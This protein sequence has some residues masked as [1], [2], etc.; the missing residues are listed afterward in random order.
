MIRINLLGEEADNSV[1]IF[2]HT[3]GLSGSIASVILACFIFHN[4]M[5]GRLEETEQE[6]SFSETTLNKLREKTKRVEQL[7]QNKNLL[8]E[9]LTTIARLKL[10]KNGPVHILD[11]LISAIP[12]RSWMTGI[13]NKG[14]GLQFEG[15]ALDPQTVSIFMAKLEVSKWFSTVELVYSSQVMDKERDYPLHK[16]AILVGLRNPIEVAKLKEKEQ[17]TEQGKEAPP[18]SQVSSRDRKEDSKKLG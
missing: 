15:I 1:K 4:S 2:L 5:L 8:K 6:A 9:K 12:E 18:P 11:D 14:E 16:F 10:K 17:Q 3:V 13:V 7:E